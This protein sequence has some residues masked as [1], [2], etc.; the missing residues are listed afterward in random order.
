VRKRVVELLEKVGESPPSPEQVG[1]RRMLE[2]LERIGTPDARRLLAA[3]AEGAPEA[4]LT[5]DARTALERL[6]GWTWPEP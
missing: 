1:R 6:R 4:R 2:L 5:Q 3:L